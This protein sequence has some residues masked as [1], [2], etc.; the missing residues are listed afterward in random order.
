MHSA[1]LVVMACLIPE[2]GCSYCSVGLPLKYHSSCLYLKLNF[3]FVRVN[4]KILFDTPSYQTKKK[5]IDY[6]ESN[7]ESLSFS[8][9]TIK[10]LIQLANS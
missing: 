5:F 4:A 8:A 2:E 6:T 10:P 1:C 7:V 9:E 3:S